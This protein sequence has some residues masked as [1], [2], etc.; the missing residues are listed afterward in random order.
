MP[1][2]EHEIKNLFFFFFLIH[3]DTEGCKVSL[4]IIADLLESGCSV[5][6]AAAA[7]PD[8]FVQHK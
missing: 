7:A 6:A 8:L 3:S 2:N 5:A 1:L 4:A